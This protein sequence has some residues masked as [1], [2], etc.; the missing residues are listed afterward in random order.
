M[1]RITNLLP[2]L[3]PRA[4]PREA[5]PDFGCP[6]C[7]GLLL[8]RNGRYGDFIGCENYPECRYTETI[9][10]YRRPVREMR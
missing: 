3:P 1:D 8:T 10:G 9:P 5:V 2:S 6:R 7:G 4:E